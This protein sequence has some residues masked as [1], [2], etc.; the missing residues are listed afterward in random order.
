MPAS[1]GDTVRVHYTGTL[2]DGTQFDSSKGRDP[3]QFTVGAGQVV[4]GFDKAVSGMEVGETKTVTIDAKDAYGEPDPNQ[5]VEVSKD[6]LPPDSN[7]SVGDQLQLG[8]QNGGSMIVRVAEVNENSILLDA[9]HPL[10]GEDLTFEITL[11][12]VA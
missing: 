3:L 6:Q 12:S 11:D 1:S 5:V 7:V 4:P 8:M 2:Q 10:A 9:N